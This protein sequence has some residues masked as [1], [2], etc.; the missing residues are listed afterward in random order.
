ML[1]WLALLPTLALAQEVQ[2][3]DAQRYRVPIDSTM[4]N[5]TDDSGVSDGDFA[6]ARLALGF[7]NDPLV[8]TSL[9]GSQ[10][11]DVVGSMVHGELAGGYN[12][13]RFRVGAQVPVLI[14]VASDLTEG[15]GGGIGDI[16][17]DGRVN[18]VDRE[19]QAVGFALG[20]RLRLPTGSVPA[21]SSNG[22][23]GE[24]QAIADVK[25]GEGLVAAN[26]GARIQPKTDLGNVIVNDQLFYRLG[27]GVPLSEGAGLSVDLSGDVNF[28]NGGVN[29]QGLP[30]EIMAG[31][32]GTV[33]DDLV[34]RGGIGTGLLPGVGA[35]N[36]RAV[37][38][39]SYEPSGDKDTDLDG[40]FDSVDACPERAEDFDQYEDE[41][42]CPELDNDG[43]GIADVDDSCPLVPEDFDGYKDEDGCVDPLV[44]VSVK[45]V[46]PNGNAVPGTAI[47]V[48]SEDFMQ[49]APNSLAFESQPERT[50][51]VDAGAPGYQALNTTFVVPEQ[52]EL[53][54]AVFNLEPEDIV[55]TMRVKVTDPEGNPIDAQW[56]IGRGDPVPVVNGAAS[57]GLEQGDYEFLFR[58]E[59][60]A[61][62]RAT[63]TV[64][65]QEERTLVVVMQPAKVK[66][67][68]GK[69]EILEKV[70]FDTG[71]ST[72]KSESFSLLEQVA[73]VLLD[74]PQI[75]K[76]S[77][78][79][80]TDQRGGASSNK[81]LSQS[82]AD[83]VM[84]FLT[85][86]GVDASRLQAVG[87]G[88]EKP[89]NEAND[90]EAWEA[91]R[92]VEF[93]ILE[94]DTVLEEV[95]VRELEGTETI[96]EPVPA[97]GAPV[98][99]APAPE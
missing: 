51:T 99:A 67:A 89:V 56:A 7:A 37:A 42:G 97:E 47:F 34:I 15:G 18:L 4:T 65:K 26:L 78:E 93:V 6:R 11:T 43:D 70:F 44:S 40:L 91:N 72:I 45:V 39:L 77:V 62:T 49:Q 69:I 80:H 14:A 38:M 35:P 64:V 17:L 88:E 24:L 20:G 2:P 96:V 30:L 50:Y 59:G 74:N 58:A 86:K 31:G 63:T 85:E 29:L 23:V 68:K 82:R 9:D 36:F 53:F 83:S 87:W 98:E 16:A 22:V 48:T 21:L 3:L 5:W 61:P 32:W 25:V 84:K 94:Q 13:G 8:F 95:E 73:D 79:G 66:I 54:E 46:D 52:D 19:I 92:R 71:K 41:D 33:S 90:A 60:F 10:R 81:R 27:Y 76:V 28:G 57:A 12:A 75:K 1:T 55:G